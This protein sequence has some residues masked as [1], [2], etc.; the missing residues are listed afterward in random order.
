MEITQIPPDYRLIE[1]ATALL[2][3]SKGRACEEDVDEFVVAI[4]HPPR[5]LTTDAR[6]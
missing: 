3:A 4:C 1:L 6:D 5:I 2:E